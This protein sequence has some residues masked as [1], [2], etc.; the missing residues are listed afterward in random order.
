MT[1]FPKKIY[2]VCSANLLVIEAAME[3]ALHDNTPVLIEATSNQVNQFGGYTG[4]TPRDFY[5]L[6]QSIA[7]AAGF[8]M[9]RV[10]L[11]GDHL[12]PLVWKNKPA[13]EAM[14]LAEEQVAAFVQAGFAKIHLDT[15]MP[16]GGD[17][18]L[19]NE[20]IAA[21]GA[22]LCAV[23][24][25]F[26]KPFYVAGSEVPTPGGPQEEVH[27]LKPTS[28]DDFLTAYQAFKNAFPP[29]AFSRVV[30]FV[31]QPGVEFTSDAVFAYDRKAASEL[32]AALP[33]GLV[34]EGHSSD[35]QT[36]EALRQMVEDGIAIL[37]V[38]PALTYALHRGLIALDTDGRFSAA[39][40]KAMLADNTHWKNHYK[41]DIKHQIH[42]SYF[43]RAR[44]Y[45][46]VPEVDCAVQEVLKGGG[47]RGVV[48]GHVKKYLEDY[49]HACK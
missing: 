47:A 40:E 39:L 45:L 26:G 25:K 2:S 34:F 13:E 29:D 6:V 15:S 33:P 18:V 44:Y 22:R 11:G 21:R 38:G 31:V 27:A 3:Q 36:R 35:Y 42:N 23:C 16:L 37:K 9:E 5:N 24:E 43:D 8:Q 32:C 12:G 10:M 19:N 17:G 7:Q 46:P 48:K 41:G 30:A 20:T 1:T 49:A 28:P 14:A 4:M